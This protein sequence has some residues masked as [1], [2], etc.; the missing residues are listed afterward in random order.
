M[1]SYQN[2]SLVIEQLKMILYRYIY[3]YAIYIYIYI[4]MI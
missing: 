1:K 2:Y 4:Y 3:T